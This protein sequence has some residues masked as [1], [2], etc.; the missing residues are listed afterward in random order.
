MATLKPK[1]LPQNQYSPRV[2]T[3]M[4]KMGQL[5]QQKVQKPVKRSGRGR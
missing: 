2:K 5:M 4:Q 1:P 3:A